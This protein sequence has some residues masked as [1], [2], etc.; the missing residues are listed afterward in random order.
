M[1]NRRVS[2]AVDTALESVRE[3]AKDEGA[4]GS[5]LDA[6]AFPDP[7]TATAASS[8]AKPVATLA[9]CPPPAPIVVAP[10]PAPAP[11]PTPAPAPAPHVTPTATDPFLAF[12]VSPAASG[13]SKSHAT[14]SEDGTIAFSHGVMSTPGSNLNLTGNLAGG[15]GGRPS[16]ATSHGT[17]TVG[18]FDLGDTPNVANATPMSANGG[19][20]GA[21]TPNSGPGSVDIGNVFS[22]NLPRRVTMDPS[23]YR[24]A[25]KAAGNDLTTTPTITESGGLDDDEDDDEVDDEDGGELGMH[26][27]GV[28]ASVPGLAA[29][30]DE[31]EDETHDAGHAPVGMSAPGHTAAFKYDASAA[32]NANA[33]EITA[34][35]PSLS[36]LAADDEDDDDHLATVNVH[37]VSKHSTNSSEASPALCGLPMGSVTEDVAANMAADLAAAVAADQAK[38][39]AGGA[40]GASAS[41]SASASS[42]DGDD[43]TMAMDLGYTTMLPTRQNAVSNGGATPTVNFPPPGAGG[44]TPTATALSDFNFTSALEAGAHG[45]WG[46]ARDTPG[47]GVNGVTMTVEMTQALNARRKSMAAQALERKRRMTLGVKGVAGFAHPADRRKSRAPFA[48]PHGISPGGAHTM[49]VDLD[50]NGAKVMGK[51]TFEF[52]YGGQDKTGEPGRPSDATK[53]SASGFGDFAASTPTLTDLSFGGAAVNDNAAGSNANADG[54]DL[55][56]SDSFEAPPGKTSLASS[57]NDTWDKSKT[58]TTTT[59]PAASSLP[60]PSTDRE[61][62]GFTLPGDDTMRLLLKNKLGEHGDATPAPPSDGNAATDGSTGSAAPPAVDENHAAADPTKTSKRTTTDT[63]DKALTDTTGDVLVP[64]PGVHNGHTMTVTGVVPF[65]TPHESLK[66]PS[67]A[68]SAGAASSTGGFTPGDETLEM[69]EKLKAREH[70]FTAKTPGTH[71]GRPSTLGWGFA[72]ALGTPLPPL[73]GA[74]PTAFTPNRNT[75]IAGG[76]PGSGFKT[77]NGHG[78]AGPGFDPAPAFGRQYGD[79]AFGAFTPGGSQRDTLRGAKALNDAKTLEGALGLPA[80]CPPIPDVGGVV[81]LETFLH[82]CEVSFMEARNLRRKSLAMESLSNAPPPSNVYEGLKL[83]CLTAPMIEGAFFQ[84]CAVS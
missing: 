25:M 13:G 45:V 81:E 80:D 84:A 67:V 40:G 37:D 7:V 20:G 39:I 69:I 42:N 76:A 68:G 28:T 71:A 47:G 34:A 16:D 46:A 50:A 72:S 4:E 2:F 21:P 11:T 29:L 66:A 60:G 44:P 62:T 74:A 49:T 43:H 1:A 27:D 78:F 59:T 53:T 38:N 35:V 31:D 26:D 32:A 70:G 83:V 33:N 75:S 73:G 63:W 6:V 18:A 54:I 15:G 58:T 41:A 52:V 30:A 55:N 9:S 57:G 77:R 64:M 24:D 22:K 23:Q 36:S 8:S 82:A 5:G 10:S 56:L 3:F 14:P 48:M 19:G 61:N 65:A 51:D 12:G 79:A 17:G